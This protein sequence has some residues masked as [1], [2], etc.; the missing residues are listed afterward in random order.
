MAGSAASAA[1]CMRSALRSATAP[2][3]G[4]SRA[5]IA[6]R[7]AARSAGTRCDPGAVERR[8]ARGV[9]HRG[10][11]AD[12]L[13]PGRRDRD[14][15][16][17]VPAVALRDRVRDGVAA[18][19]ALAARHLDEAAED[20]ARRRARA[21]ARQRRQLGRRQRQAGGARRRQRQRREP[22]R[23]RR[24][25]GGGRDAVVAG[26]Q[27]AARDLGARAHEIEER[28]HA[29]GRGVVGGRAVEHQ[30][31]A[32]RRRRTRPSCACPADPASATGCP[33]PAG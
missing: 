9:R 12:R 17:H 27:R 19:G 3:A 30:P 16:A 15:Q 4:R 33:S 7:A 1:A 22:R 5:A 8:G 2:S 31:I 29:R 23:R 28:R 18:V 25:A 10:G 32:P 6:A 26:D 11:R 21:D 13:G 24:Q 14:D 20:R